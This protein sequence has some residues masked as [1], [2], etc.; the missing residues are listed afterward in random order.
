M[1]SISQAPGAPSGRI[2]KISWFLLFSCYL[3]GTM[4][5]KWKKHRLNTHPIIH[6]PTSEGVSEVAVRS[7][8]ISEWCERTSRQTSERPSTSVCIPGYSSPQ[9]TRRLYSLQTQ[10]S[11]YNST[12]AFL[13]FLAPVST[14]VQNELMPNIIRS[15]V[16]FSMRSGLPS[17]EWMSKRVRK[18]CSAEQVNE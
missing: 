14:M 17:R 12:F 13:S 6:C 11:M 10:R 4:G 9:W 8:R 5:Q 18:A 3:Q 2:R 16:H 15:I 7:K 1:I